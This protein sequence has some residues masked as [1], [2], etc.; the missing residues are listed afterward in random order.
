MRQAYAARVRGERQ[1][2]ATIRGSHRNFHYLYTRPF[3]SEALSKNSSLKA[4]R[5]FDAV[6]ERLNMSTRSIP[7]YQ[8]RYRDL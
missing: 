3:V 4:L 6:V 5:H 2:P 7:G 8:S 1:R